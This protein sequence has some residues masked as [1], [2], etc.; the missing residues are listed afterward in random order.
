METYYIAPGHDSGFHHT[1]GGVGPVRVACPLCQNSMSLVFGYDLS[2]P[3][4]GLGDWGVEQLPCL[5]CMHCEMFE[6]QYQVAP[7]GI[8]LLEHD[9]CD[10]VDDEHGKFPGAENIPAT[11]L[12]LVRLSDELQDIAARIGHVTVTADED[13]RFTV[14]AE[15]DRRFAEWYRRSIERQTVQPF[16]HVGKLVYLAAKGSPTTCAI[17][18][19]DMVGFAALYDS[20]TVKFDYRNVLCQYV[21]SFCRSCRV[22]HGCIYSS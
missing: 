15:E 17:C 7:D 20:G 16:P 3:R 4:L 21:F 18:K 1:T 13:R 19:T 6:I 12:R 5:Y 2:D 10:Y 11:V 14:T 9:G 8:R 22:V